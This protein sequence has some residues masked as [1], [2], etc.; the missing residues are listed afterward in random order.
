[1]PPWKQGLRGVWTVR[2]TCKKSIMGVVA[3]LRCAFVT[4]NVVVMAMVASA[5][6]CLASF[7]ASSWSPLDI[8][9]LPGAGRGC[10]RF[11]GEPLLLNRLRAQGS[12]SRRPSRRQITCPRRKTLLADIWSF[13]SLPSTSSC[14]SSILLHL[15]G[16]LLAYRAKLQSLTTAQLLPPSPNPT[17]AEQQSSR[18]HLHCNSTCKP[19]P[20]CILNPRRR[21]LAPS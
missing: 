6:A 13:A 12:V 17:V 18:R 1:M 2:A 19:T 10:R 20:F 5:A 8:A 4:M 9:R 3:L 11:R 16:L 15:S 14:C 7:S 21:T